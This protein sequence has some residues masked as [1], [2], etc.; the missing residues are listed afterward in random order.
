MLD[1]PDQLGKIEVLAL[2]PRV[3]DDVGEQDV[4]GVRYRI[5][6]DPGHGQQPR[7]ESLDLV[8]NGLSVRG[9]VQLRGFQGSDEAERDSRART[10]RVDR[11]VGALTEGPDTIRTD[12]PAFES[13]LPEARSA[14]CELTDVDSLAASLGRVY[15]RSE[16]IGAQIRKRQEEVAHVSL[17]I[18]DQHRNPREQ[19]LL[20]ED[21]PHARLAG[22]GHAQD[23]SVR[24]QVV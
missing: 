24:R 23:D 13:L 22:A 4:L 6:P 12:A 17:W 18:Q 2:A 20:E 8:A 9:P 1:H 7:D 3:L 5:R 16:G 21:D 19:R 10:G 11:E 15:P 14:L